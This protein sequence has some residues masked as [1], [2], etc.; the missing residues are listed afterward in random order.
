MAF[1]AGREII[2][3]SVTPEMARRVD[4]RCV[5][6]GRITGI[7]PTRSQITKLAIQTYLDALAEGTEKGS[8]EDSEHTYT[9]VG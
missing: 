3:A 4:E 2:S 8:T 5:E 7:A 6:L 9:T 1:Q